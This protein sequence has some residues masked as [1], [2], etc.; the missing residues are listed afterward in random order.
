M[1]YIYVA[2]WDDSGKPIASSNTWD[3]LIEH[4][5]EYNDMPFIKYEA[6]N[7]KYPDSLDGWFYYDSKEGEDKF[8]VYCIEFK[9]IQK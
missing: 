5:N 1:N 9:H 7:P 2:C 6:Y 3:G 4:L 8:K